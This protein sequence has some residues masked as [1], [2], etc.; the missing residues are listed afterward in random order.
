[1]HITQQYKTAPQCSLAGSLEFRQ[2]SNTVE[3]WRAKVLHSLKWSHANGS[4][5]TNTVKYTNVISQ[6]SRVHLSLQ[7]LSTCGTYSCMHD[8]MVSLADV[9]I[10][11]NVSTYWP[12]TWIACLTHKNYSQGKVNLEAYESKW[13]FLMQQPERFSFNAEWTRFLGTGGV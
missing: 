5:N 7:Q 13:P 11:V 2:F 1:M 10:C 4:N 6:D 3:V 9:I 8:V 12:A